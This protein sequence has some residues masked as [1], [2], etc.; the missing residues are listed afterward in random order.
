MY[1]YIYIHTVLPSNGYFINESHKSPVFVN[2]GFQD[3]KMFVLCL[4]RLFTT[5]SKTFYTPFTGENLAI[6]KEDPE[7]NYIVGSLSQ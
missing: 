1:I 3:T 7:R 5:V 4:A 2:S 6:I